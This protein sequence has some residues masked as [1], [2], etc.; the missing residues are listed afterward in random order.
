VKKNY[1]KV[2]IKKITHLPASVWSAQV[3]VA[4]PIAM[5]RLFPFL[6][7][8]IH[9]VTRGRG[10][11]SQTQAMQTSVWLVVSLESV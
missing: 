8:D 3:G 7:F 9:A 5:Q 1:R 10:G 4:V 6:V 11:L 2:K